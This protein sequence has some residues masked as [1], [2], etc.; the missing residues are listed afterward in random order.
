M[1]LVSLSDRICICREVASATKGLPHR[2]Q[3]E[4]VMLG[5]SLSRCAICL[6]DERADRVI[7]WKGATTSERPLGLATDAEHLNGGARMT[8][9]K[10][11]VASMRD[12]MLQQGSDPVGRDGGP[13]IH[14][15]GVRPSE[16]HVARGPET[17]LG[18]RNFLLIKPFIEDVARCD[19]YGQPCPT[20]PPYVQLVIG[21]QDTA[22]EWARN[23]KIYRKLT[24]KLQKHHKEEYR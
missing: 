2:Y 15:E 4:W 22:V 20:A 14:R 13:P 23:H 6:I 7:L 5:G 24:N 17:S 16:G 8:K 19:F 1:T 11:E 10:W 18:P 9:R 21:K 12:K 3:V